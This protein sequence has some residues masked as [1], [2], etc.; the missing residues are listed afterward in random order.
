M[1]NEPK[2]T[3]AEAVTPPS[4]TED[5]QIKGAHQ[6]DTVTVSCPPGKRAKVTSKTL[7]DGTSETIV[8]CV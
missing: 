5:E 6:R 8:K 3:D 1:S 4:T 7:K 2:E